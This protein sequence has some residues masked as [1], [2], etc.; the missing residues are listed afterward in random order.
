VN[1]V[2]PGRSRYYLVGHGANQDILR[3]GGSL[4]V[5]AALLELLKESHEWRSFFR[6]CCETN[7][8]RLR[9]QVWQFCEELANRGHK[10]QA[11][12]VE[13]T[14]LGLARELLPDTLA[15]QWNAEWAHNLCKDALTRLAKRY[16]EFSTA[17]KEVL[18][19]SVQEVWD[20]R[21]HAAGLANDP[22][23]FRMALKGWE[24]AGLEAMKWVRVK[25][26][27]A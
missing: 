3:C 1:Q 24:R 11:E 4:K 2:P 5:R 22:A 10:V 9:S 6:S 21:M 23:A 12:E 25:G 20:E 8:L 13:D 19:L 15:A 16:A 26:G 14:L 18:D 7:A 17:E 27:A